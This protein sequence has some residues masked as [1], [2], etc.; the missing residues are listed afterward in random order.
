MKHIKVACISENTS[1]SKSLL[2]SHGQSLLLEID[3]KKYLFDTTEIY[4]GLSYNMNRMN[5]NLNDIQTVVLSHNHLDHSRALFKLIDHFTDQ[6]L[7]L[8]PD[9]STIDEEGY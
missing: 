8:P 7:F 4:E 5:V 1:F 9:M 6:R 3:E 2:A